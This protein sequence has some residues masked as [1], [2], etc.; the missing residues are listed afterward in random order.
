MEGPGHALWDT[1]GTGGECVGEEAEVE[2][3]SEHAEFEGK[4]L[5]SLVY[6]RS[7]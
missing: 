4:S 7:R 6:G 1:E 3:G 2:A 5:V